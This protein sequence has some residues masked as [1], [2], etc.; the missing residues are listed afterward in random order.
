MKSPQRGDTPESSWAVFQKILHRQVLRDLSQQTTTEIQSPKTVYSDLDLFL[1]GIAMESIAGRSLY[2]L[3]EMV[4]NRMELARTD[5]NRG[6]QPR[7]RRTLYAPTEDDTTFRHK[8]IQGE[9][10]DQNT[11][12]LGGVA[13]H[14]GLFGTM[15]DLSSYGLLLRGA[16]QGKKSKRFA[17]TDAVRLFTKRAIPRRQGDW[18][19]DFMMPSKSGASC[20]D[21]FSQSSVGHLGFTGTSLWYD[22]EKDLLVTILSNRI[23]PSV[24]NI[25][26]RKLR[27]KIHTWIAEEL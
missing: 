2:E 18:A 26:I 22:P 11:W 19:L 9:V 14:A 13:P 7:Y 15:D 20:G 25:E 21:L 24:E 3:W 16:M 27:P 4:N 6:N 17:S 1:I 12:A 5:F 23:H 10:H 8:L